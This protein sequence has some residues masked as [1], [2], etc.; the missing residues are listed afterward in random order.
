MVS[1]D[2]IVKATG[3]HFTKRS[4]Q[5]RH[6]RGLWLTKTTA[7]SAGKPYDYSE[8]N[9]LEVVI[10]AQLM[11]RGFTH[12][13]ANG[14]MKYRTRGAFAGEGGYSS[15]HEERLSDLPEIK[16]GA[17]FWGIVARQDEGWGLVTSGVV[18]ADSPKTIFDALDRP[19]FFFVLNVGGIVTAARAALK[20]AVE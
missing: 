2:Q 13:S 19:D 12:E 17:G 1:A 14:V 8:A 7:P 3:G 11:Q 15:Q 9:A 18:V 4:I 5:H 6:A 16:N 20:A 10:A